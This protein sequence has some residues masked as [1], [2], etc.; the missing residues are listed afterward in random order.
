MENCKRYCSVL[1]VFGFKSAQYDLNLIKSSLLP[2]LVNEKDIEPTNI[3]KVNQFI[4]FQFGDVQLSDIVIFLGGA[5]SLELFL[6]AYKASKK[7]GFPLRTVRSP[8]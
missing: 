4:C 1:R 7:K 6:K 8:R 3:K 5:L 2:L